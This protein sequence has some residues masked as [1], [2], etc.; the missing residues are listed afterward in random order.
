MRTHYTDTILRILTSLLIL[1]GLLWFV[2][3][4]WAHAAAPA[5]GMG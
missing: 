4:G 5:L 2:L 1:S 3:S